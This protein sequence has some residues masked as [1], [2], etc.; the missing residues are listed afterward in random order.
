MFSRFKT[1]GLGGVYD[2]QGLIC[3]YFTYFTIV[4]YVSS[5]FFLACLNIHAK[6]LFGFHFEHLLLFHIR[7]FSFSSNKFTLSIRF[8]KIDWQVMLL[9]AL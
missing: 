9:T 7:V 8:K 3:E 4:F 1:E 6:Q 2:K 5:F